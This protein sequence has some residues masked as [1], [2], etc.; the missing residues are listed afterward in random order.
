M[1]LPSMFSRRNGPFQ[2]VIISLMLIITSVVVGDNPALG[3]SCDRTTHDYSGWRKKEWMDSW[4]NK[5]LFIPD[6]LLTGGSNSKS[7]IGKDVFPPR[8]KRS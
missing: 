2:V 3:L 1:R 6:N 7:I 5:K 4:F 8:V